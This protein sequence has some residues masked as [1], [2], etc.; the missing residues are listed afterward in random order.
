MQGRRGQGAVAGCG[1]VTRG[2]RD[3]QWARGNGCTPREVPLPAL[4]GH[5]IE[6]PKCTTLL[7][8]P[9]AASPL[10]MVSDPAT[11]YTPAS[12]YTPGRGEL[13]PPP[14]QLVE[15]F[16][17]D[18]HAVAVEEAQVE[19]CGTGGAFLLVVG[20]A[21]VGGCWGRGGFFWRV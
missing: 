13:P 14:A 21:W 15:K 3:F 8:A 4:V 9:A 18:R 7:L 17:K 11:P 12:H 16:L 6:A 19:V 5:Q 1:A 2:K 20:Q 10:S